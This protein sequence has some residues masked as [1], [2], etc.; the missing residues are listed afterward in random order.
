LF[1]RYKSKWEL[2]WWKWKQQARS[3][4]SNEECYGM[5]TTEQADSK[6][7]TKQ[8]NKKQKGDEADF[9]I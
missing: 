9:I 2:N 6:D 8:Q 4:M 3:K 7:S 5:A 1:L